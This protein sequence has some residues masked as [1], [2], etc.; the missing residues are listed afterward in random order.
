M[1]SILKTSAEPTPRFR[2]VRIGSLYSVQSRY[3]N[4]YITVFVSEVQ[5]E[6]ERW[7]G[8]CMELPR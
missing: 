7:F 2:L 8:L 6:S 4:R 1:T 3:K 5:T